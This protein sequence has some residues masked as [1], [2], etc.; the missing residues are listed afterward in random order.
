[1]KHLNSLIL[2]GALCLSAAANAEDPKF[3]RI[4]TASLGGNFFPMGA[5]VAAVI[6][7][8]VPGGFKA[9]AQAS[10]GS[11]F[12]MTAIQDGEQELAIC[13][14]PA[15]S[16]AVADGDTP[17]VRGIGNYNATPQHIL[18]RKAANIKSVADLKGKKL[19]MIGAGDGV[20]VS[21]RK[22]LDAFGI[23]WDEI[24]PEYSGN[25]VQAAA[26]LKTGQ[27]DA[28]IDATGVGSSW[29]TDIVGDGSRFELLP[30]SES[31]IEKVLAANKEFS[32]MPI[33]ANAYRGQ[34]K[35]IDAVG[36]WTVIVVSN[37]LSDNLVYDITKAIFDNA[38]FLKE[39]HNYFKD[40]APENIKGA[41]IVPLHAGAEKFYK[42]KG[43]LQ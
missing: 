9:T 4:G 23:K 40:L 36:V 32:R 3:L 39:R 41:I 43:I 35:V 37:K 34:D 2:A 22:M 42:E 12:N 27:V 21:S 26:R 24:T 7:N 6:D 29:I 5:A 19:E 30:L 1:M 28:I 17:D 15:V 16:Q 14:G 8:H 38:Q 25:R 11:A 10:S 31:E 13:Q 18:V 33:P 20:E